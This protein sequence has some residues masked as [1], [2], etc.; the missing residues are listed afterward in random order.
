MTGMAVMLNTDDIDSCRI[1]R[2]GDSCNI[3]RIEDGRDIGR[4][5]DS[6][7]I[8]KVIVDHTLQEGPQVMHDYLVDEVDHDPKRVG[9]YWLVFWG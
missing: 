5:M 9:H 6:G 1:R 2:I 7:A 4:A 8:K 3:W